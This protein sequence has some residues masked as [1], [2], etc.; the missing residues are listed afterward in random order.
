MQLT[1]FVKCFCTLYNH[2]LLG[3]IK[4]ILHSPS[5]LL[6]YAVLEGNFHKVVQDMASLEIHQFSLT[7]VTQKRVFLAKQILVFMVYIW[8]TKDLVL[9]TLLSHTHGVIVS[10]IRKTRIQ[11]ARTLVAKIEV[12]DLGV[13]LTISTKEDREVDKGLITLVSLH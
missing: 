12:E 8:T 10:T 6:I 3:T 5:L 13:D 11:V 4:Q 1:V 7:V 9:F 2:M